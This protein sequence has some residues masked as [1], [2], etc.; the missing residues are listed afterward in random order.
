LGFAAFEGGA[1]P[2]F[3]ALSVGEPV[4]AG[5]AGAGQDRGADA[6][7]PG[8]GL[9]G[10]PVDGDLAV[11]ALDPEPA[12][13]D[14]VVVEPAQQDEVVQVGGPAEFPVVQVVGDAVLSRDGAGG[15]LAA[16]VAYP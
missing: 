12:F 11:S 6:Q 8:D 16:A 14:G 10:G 2:F 3:D 5:P 7:V 13:V 1:E 15:E 4:G 9:P